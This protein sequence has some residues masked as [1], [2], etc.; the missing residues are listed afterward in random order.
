LLAGAGVSPAGIAIISP[1]SVNLAFKIS[2]IKSWEANIL[3]QSLLSLGSDAGIERAAL[4]KDKKT[5]VIILGSL[6]QLNKLCKRLKEQPSGLK[7]LSLKLSL[8]L[9]DFFKEEFKFCARGKTLKI[10]K[11]IICGIINV[12]D[13]SFSGDGLLNPIPDRRSQTTDLALKK[14]GGMVKAG[15]RI[16][17]VG[18]ESSRPGASPIDEKEEIKRVV[19]VLRM[20]RKEFPGIFISVDTYKYKVARAAAG[21]GA[22]IINDI[23]ALR[24]SPRIISLLKKYKMG[25]VLMHMKGSPRNMQVNPV[26]RDVMESIVDFFNE[27]LNIAYAGGLAPEQII[28]DPGIGFGKTLEHNLKIIKEL[29]KLKIFGLPILLGASRKSFIG[30]V[31]GA[32]EDK[33]LTGTLA[34]NVV[35]LTRGAGIF[36]VH[37][38]K[39]AKDALAVAYEIMGS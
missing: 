18:G 36:R 12:T 20:L 24:H 13:D 17:D 8:S 33:R 27:R 4:V 14:A 37:D 30:R 23:T 21:A 3:K 39:E 29:Y 11:P 1:K 2:G 25:C 10:K 32:G 38:V 31:I 35:S 5:D 9:R 22:D 28:I 15:A 16:L 26:Y 7:E 19:P 6:S 34:A